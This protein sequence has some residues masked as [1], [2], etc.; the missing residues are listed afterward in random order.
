MIAVWAVVDWPGSLDQG[1]HFLGRTQSPW[2][3][4]SCCILASFLLDTRSSMKQQIPMCWDRVPDSI[5]GTRIAVD[6]ETREIDRESSIDDQ[7]KQRAEE[8]DLEVD[9]GAVQVE[10]FLEAGT[11]LHVDWELDLREETCHLL[12]P[13][14][15]LVGSS[16][17]TSTF[18]SLRLVQMEQSGVQREAC[19]GCHE[20]RAGREHWASVGFHQEAEKLPTQ[21]RE[22]MD[23]DAVRVD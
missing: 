20:R 11:W 19:N 21:V 4:Y 13:L 8:V 3:T 14:G 1:H 9:L 5:E 7:G 12:L 17:H 10:H 16:D 15:K 6:S 18:S 2:G 23:S 22:E